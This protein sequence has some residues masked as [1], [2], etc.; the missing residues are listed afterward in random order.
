MATPESC[1]PEAHQYQGTP[2][3]SGRSEFEPQRQAETGFWWEKIWVRPCITCPMVLP[4]ILESLRGLAVLIGRISVLGLTQAAASRAEGIDRTELI[5]AMTAR[6]TLSQ[7]FAYNA[8]RIDDW[9][10]INTPN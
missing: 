4:L 7:P 5:A 2:P 3:L 1:G 8:R 6:G 10:R 9:K